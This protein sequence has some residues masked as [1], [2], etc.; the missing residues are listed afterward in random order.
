MA[1][2]ARRHLAKEIVTLQP[3]AMC[4][5]GATSLPK[6]TQAL[7][8]RRASAEPRLERCESWTGLVSL[9]DQPVRGWEDKTRAA[10]TELW[11]GR[12]KAHP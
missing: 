7:F 1:F 6:V 12:R 9:V 10:L 3:R 2:C 8:G 4:F 11:K 5:L